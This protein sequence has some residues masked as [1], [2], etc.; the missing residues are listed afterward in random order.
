MATIT[1]NGTGGGNW[2]TGSTWNGGVVPADD[3]AIWI[4]DTWDN[5]TI[6]LRDRYKKPIQQYSSYRRQ[7]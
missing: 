4:H 3:D 6:R 7:A 5:A 1:S 2:G